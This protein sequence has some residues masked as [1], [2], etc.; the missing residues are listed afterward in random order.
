MQTDERQLKDLVSIGPAT[1]D[2]FELLGIDSVASFGYV[3]RSACISSCAG[4]RGE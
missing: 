3:T 2:D 1:L 4:S